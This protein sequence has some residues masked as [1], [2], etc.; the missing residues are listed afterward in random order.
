[1]EARIRSARFSGSAACKTRVVENPKDRP[2]VVL[3]IAVGG[4]KCVGCSTQPN[5]YGDDFDRVLIPEFLQRR[6]GLR[7]A[8]YV[9]CKWRLFVPG[10]RIA[11]VQGHLGPGTTR[12]VIE[13]V[14]SMKKLGF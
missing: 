4:Y 6:C 3:S 5:E 2:A 8:T 9:C 7:Q 14:A 12:A 10:N 13:K 1:M 11:R